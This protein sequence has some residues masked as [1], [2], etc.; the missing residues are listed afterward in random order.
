MLIDFDGSSFDFNTFLVGL[1][2]F[3]LK[4]VSGYLIRLVDLLWLS[5]KNGETFEN[6]LSSGKVHGV[7]TQ[8]RFGR[9]SECRA[10]A[11]QAYTAN[12]SHMCSQKPRI[13]Q[14]PT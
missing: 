11:M 7:S 6:H 9:S 3:V 4:D 14:V 8:I 10:S 5:D 13:N 2:G 12:R 1:G